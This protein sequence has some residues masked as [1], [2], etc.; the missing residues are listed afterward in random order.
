MGFTLN[1]AM[2]KY[3]CRNLLCEG[4]GDDLLRIAVILH[5]ARGESDLA[6][7]DQDGLYPQP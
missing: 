2:V 4:A 6:A 5:S 7:T 3:T 1:A